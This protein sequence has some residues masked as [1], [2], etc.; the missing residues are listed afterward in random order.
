[1]SKLAVVRIGGRQYQVREGEVIKVE[2]LEGKIGD[3]KNFDQVL[4]LADEAGNEVKVGKP[5]V[6]GAK[7]AGEIL[8]QRRSKK[9]L[10]IKFKSKVRYQRKKGHRQFYTKVKIEKIS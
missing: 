5:L 7:V 3:K 10:V 4:L 1:M 9:I 2:K 6:A 8:E